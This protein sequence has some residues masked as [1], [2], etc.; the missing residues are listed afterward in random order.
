MPSKVKVFAWRMLKDRIPTRMQ[1]LHRNIIEVNEDC[2]CV[3]GCSAIEDVQHLFL[4][5]GKMRTVWINIYRWL[6][7]HV[8]FTV[9]CGNHLLQF[10]DNLKRFCPVKRAA[11]LWAAVCWCA[12]K[13]R[14]A[15]LFENAM[16][17]LEDLVH[18]VKMYSW[19]WM[20]IGCRKM[21]VCSFYDWPCN[22]GLIS[23]KKLGLSLVVYST[24]Q[25]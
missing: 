12:W 2:C 23:C 17:D 24:E 4:D 15:I 13:H 19:W 5:C 20:A 8:D 18:K 1:L 7:I 14:N 25:L 11:S 9:D 10:V 6:G 21:V 3:L 22:V 16:E